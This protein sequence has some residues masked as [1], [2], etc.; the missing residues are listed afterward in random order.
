MCEGGVLAVVMRH[1]TASSVPGGVAVPEQ[2]GGGR[3][4]LIFVCLSLIC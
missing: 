3:E 1:Y 4:G 2:P